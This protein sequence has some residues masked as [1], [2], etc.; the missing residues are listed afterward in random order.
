MRK[1]GKRGM[2]MKKQFLLLILFGWL[3]LPLFQ[4]EQYEIT[5]T[6]IAVPARVLDGDR[7]IDNLTIGDFELLEDGVPQKIQALYLVRNKILE[8]KETLQEFDPSFNRSFYLLFQMTEYNPKLTELIDYLFNQVILSGDNLL[9]QTPM[10]NYGLSPQAFATK[11][12]KVLADDMNSLLKKD[13][14]NGNTEYNSLLSDLKRIVRNISG[15][16]PMRDMEE[17][18]STAPMGLEYML[19]RYKETIQRMDQNRLMDEKKILR[20]AYALKRVPGQKNVF[21]IYQREFRP[22]IQPMVLN[23][24]MSMYQDD[25]NIMGDLQDLFQYYTRDISLNTDIIK[26]AFA[27]SSVNFNFIYMNKEPENV[28]GVNMKEQSEDVFRVFSQVAQATGGVSDSSQ[29]P[30]AS[31]EHAI[32]SS[33]IYYLLYYSPQNYKKDGQ[34]KNITLKVKDQNDTVLH[35]LGYFAE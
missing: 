29:N 26:K 11:P 2:P 25:P 27:D 28:S 17:T 22:E 32:K 19:N 31:F 24:L 12:K 18:D 23:Q 20:F 14:K 7:F 8:R 4:Q 16:S 1:S 33:E 6:N 21:F 13:I 10:K 5:V 34:F 9:L 3:A 30:V 35:R 15:V